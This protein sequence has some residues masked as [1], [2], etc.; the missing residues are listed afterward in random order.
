VLLY[1]SD[2]SLTFSNPGGGMFQKILV[3][4]DGTENSERILPYVIEQALQ[5]KSK[6]ILLRVGALSPIASGFGSPERLT[7]GF[8]LS[9]DVMIRS[10]LIEAESYLKKI[11][12]KLKEKG[13]DVDIETIIGPVADAII[14]FIGDQS[15][16]L[17]AMTTNTYK[18]WKR[19]FFGNTFDQILKNCGIPILVMHF[20]QSQL[21]S[22]N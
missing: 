6:L 5:F 1:V 8:P 22:L 18:G 17:V 14:K 15:I 13:L 2:R 11:A 4:L 7:L 16:D 10:E 3:Y 9:S 21:C 12:G 19:L 20:S